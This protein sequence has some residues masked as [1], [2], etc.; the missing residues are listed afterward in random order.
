M[1]YYA[2]IGARELPTEI[3]DLMVLIG[4]WMAEENWILRSGGAKG[5]DTAF[6]TGCDKAKGEK[7][8]FLPQKGYNGNPSQLYNIPEEAYHLA[9]SKWDLSKRNQLVKNLYARNCQQILGTNLDCPSA[10]VICWTRN[11]EPIGGTG[12]A[13]QIARE[14]KIPVINLFHQQELLKGN[15]SN[16]LKHLKTSYNCFI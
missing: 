15:K 11:G 5:A 3:Y 8:I 4:I 1:K 14:F 2:G 13:I 16:F 12:K 9:N 10:L 7:E 6:E